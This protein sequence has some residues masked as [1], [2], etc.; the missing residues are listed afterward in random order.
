MPYFVIT[1]R[2]FPAQTQ[3]SHA[4]VNTTVA[5]VATQTI[6]RFRFTYR[7]S[8]TPLDSSRCVFTR[9]LP[10]VSWRCDGE[11]VTTTLYDKDGRV[12]VD[13]LPLSCH[14]STL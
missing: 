5:S 8:Y 4:C 3:L 2:F 12:S 7:Y 1:V 9:D 11:F 14:P 13:L 6:V 10:L